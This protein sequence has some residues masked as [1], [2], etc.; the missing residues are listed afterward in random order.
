MKAK[1]VGDPSQPAGTE[2]IPETMTH[3]GLVFEKGKFTEVP[4]EL[5]A[6]FAGNNHFETQGKEPDAEAK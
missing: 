5:A 6:K 2:P 4:D 1:F 3:L